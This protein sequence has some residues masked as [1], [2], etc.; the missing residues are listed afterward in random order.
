MRLSHNNAPAFGK[1]FTFDQFF[2]VFKVTI[3][4]LKAGF[5]NNL[6]PGEAFAGKE[7]ALPVYAVRPEE[8]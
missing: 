2:V 7:V 3:L 6:S 4:H 5:H 1:V 8:G